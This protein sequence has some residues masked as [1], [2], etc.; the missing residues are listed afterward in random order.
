MY[1]EH[2]IGEALRR[3]GFDMYSLMTW[4][5]RWDRA[6]PPLIRVGVVLLF[7][8]LMRLLYLTNPGWFGAPP[9]IDALGFPV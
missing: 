3:R 9:A 8:W 5:A 6:R 1:L 4:H 2:V 7:A